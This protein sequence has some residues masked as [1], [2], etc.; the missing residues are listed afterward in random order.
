M[1]MTP[2]EKD[3]QLVAVHPDSVLGDGSSP[4]ARGVEVE[5]DDNETKNDDEDEFDNDF[6]YNS[7]FFYPIP[8]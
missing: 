5:G 6:L 4:L 1:L 2:W 3:L 8:R 7:N